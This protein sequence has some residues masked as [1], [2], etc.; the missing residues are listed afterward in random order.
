M[1]LSVSH[2][3]L[4]AWRSAKRWLIAYSGGVDSHVLLHLVAQFRD[5]STETVPELVAIHVNH[6]LQQQ[7]AAWA[8]H[9]QRVCDQLEIPLLIETVSVQCAGGESLEA[10]ARKAR[11]QAFE[12]HLQMDDLLMMAH[13]LDD[14]LETW[15]LRLLRGSGSQGLGAMVKQRDFAGATLLRPLLDIPSQAIDEFACAEGLQWVEDPSNKDTEFSR[16]Y[17]RLEVLPKLEQQ[18]PGYRQSVSRALK[19]SQQS[20]ELNRDLAVI[21][22]QQAAV[23]PLAQALPM[24]K[25]LGL[26][27]VRQKNLLRYCLQQ[28]GLPLPTSAQL[29]AVLDEV[30]HAAEDANPRVQWGGV[31]ARRF[32]GQ[33]YVFSTLPAF[34]VGRVC[35][36]LPPEVLALEGNGQLSSEP[37]TGVGLR[38][39]QALTVRFRQG[40]ERCQPAGRSGSQTLKKL[41]QEYAVP[42]WL[43]DRVPLIYVDNELAAV[44]GYWVCEAYLARQGEAGISIHWSLP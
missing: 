31:E 2:L 23:D 5:Q 36:W 1:T 37:V 20:N 33:L 25:V 43:R 28:R 41:F 4:D 6:Q 29:Q 21:D 12:K 9:C 42:T 34:D 7:S 40:G 11:Y 24:E 35:P 8:Q 32:R 30:I 22:C 26:S 10:Q 19:L 13:H 16:N 39:G 44:A 14:Q 15:F 18:W 27:E 3:E 38:L 17:L